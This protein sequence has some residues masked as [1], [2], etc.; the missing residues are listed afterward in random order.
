MVFIAV[1]MDRLEI[2]PVSLFLSFM[3][4]LPAAYLHFKK[5]YVKIRLGL[6]LGFAT[7]PGVVLGVLIGVQT[8]DS[9]AYGSFAVLLFATAFKMTYDMYKKKFDSEQPDKD[10]SNKQVVGLCGLSVITG[11]VSAFF[12]VGGGIVTVPVLIYLLG[13][14]PRRAIGT[15]AFMIVMTSITGFICYYILTLGD[16]EVFGTALRTVPSIEFELALILGL[17]VFIGAYL[18]SSWGLK[19]L[20]TKNVQ[21]VFIIIIFFVGIQLMLKS[22]GIL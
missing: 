17:V 18:G 1:S 13:L 6:L 21:M 14:Y 10:Y 5:N 16:F 7:I 2:I 22:L 11:M 4:Q 12:G 20:K 15:S 8:Q 9:L 3:T 19:E